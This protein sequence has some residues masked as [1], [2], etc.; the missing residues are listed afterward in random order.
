MY[1]ETILLLG[2]SIYQKLYVDDKEPAAHSP[3]A[4]GDRVSLDLEP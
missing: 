3:V 1:S 2:T 4:A